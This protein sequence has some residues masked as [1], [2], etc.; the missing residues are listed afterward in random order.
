MQRP[1]FTRQPS[2]VILHGRRLLGLRMRLLIQVLLSFC[3]RRRR[4]FSAPPPHQMRDCQRL[5]FFSHCPPQATKVSVFLR[6]WKPAIQR[7][8]SSSVFDLPHTSLPS[9]NISSPHRRAAYPP[10]T[11]VLE[12]DLF[13]PTGLSF[14]P[15][16]FLAGAELDF[17]FLSYLQGSDNPLIWKSSFPWRMVPLLSEPSPRR[18]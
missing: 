14:F 15:D 1:P 7:T 16:D 3:S 10:P 8:D 6:P 9:R 4:R 11:P 17:H 12:F 13:H 2:E 18:L 5:T